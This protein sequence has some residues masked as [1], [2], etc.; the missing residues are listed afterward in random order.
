MQTD[1]KSKGEAM[2]LSTE[3]LKLGLRSYSINNNK[4][5]IGARN[6]VTDRKYGTNISLSIYLLSTGLCFTIA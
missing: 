5:Y 4:E 1:V 6:Y 2:E 3:G